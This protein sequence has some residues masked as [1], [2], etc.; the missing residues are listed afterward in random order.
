MKTG[1]REALAGDIL[2]V[3]LALLAVF[4]VLALTQVVPPDFVWGRQAANRSTQRMILESISL[5]VTLLFALIV[6]I[7]M[8]YVLPGRF[9]V[10][11]AIGMWIMVGYFVLNT[12]GNLASGIWVEKLIFALLTVVMA[13]CA[14]RLAIS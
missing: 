4:H 6:A 9:E 1:I 11:I 10:P 8:D 13:L 2:L 12:I 14:F 7:R 5:V 3:G